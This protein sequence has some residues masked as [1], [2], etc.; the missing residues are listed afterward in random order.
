MILFIVLD[1]FDFEKIEF[2][3]KNK[4][5][6]TYNR[7]LIPLLLGKTGN[8]TAINTVGSAWKKTIQRYKTEKQDESSERNTKY[9]ELLTLLKEHL[10]HESDL[11]NYLDDFQEIDAKK[12]MQSTSQTDKILFGKFTRFRE[13]MV[14]NLNNFKKNSAFREKVTKQIFDDNLEFKK[15]I[16]IEFTYIFLCLYIAKNYSYFKAP[17]YKN[18]IQDRF[19]SEEKF[20]EEYYRVLTDKSF[21]TIKNLTCFCYTQY[22]WFDFRLSDSN[23]SAIHSILFG[24]FGEMDISPMTEIGFEVEQKIKQIKEKPDDYGFKYPDIKEI[25]P[26]HIELNIVVDIPSDDKSGLKQTTKKGLIDFEKEN[27]RNQRLGRQGERIVLYGERKFLKENGKDDLSKKIEPTFIL[28]DYAGYD[29]K[30]YELDGSQKYIEVK[31]TSSKP[32]SI[33]FFISAPEYEKAKNLKN[34][35][36]YIVFEAK[37][38]NPKI[39]KIRD[40][41]QFEGKGLQLIPHKYRVIINTKIGY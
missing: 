27:K 16:P 4:K 25:E 17:R 34:Y 23:E 22:F 39:W 9:D 21:A 30:S 26:E 13:I 33:T 6:E 19:I 38:K 8:Q 32:H 18:F 10:S 3:F 7:N 12:L 5:F 41:F 15:E 35:Y 29:I 11:L 28:D 36:I 14:N 37:T 31:T 2:E 24:M 1:Y 40:P 20:L